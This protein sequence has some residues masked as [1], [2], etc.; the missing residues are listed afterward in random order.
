LDRDQILQNL[1]NRKLDDTT[2]TRVQESYPLS[3]R[4]PTC[5]GT[6]KYMLNGE[7]HACDCQLQLLLQ[8]HYFASNIGREYHDICA[9]SHF[10]GPDRDLVI[11]VIREYLD[12]YED[13][14]HYGIGLTFSGPLG[15]GKTFA[16]TSVLKDLIQRGH[17]VYFINFN[18]MIEVWG[19]SWHDDKAKKML[20]DKLKRVDVLGIDEV[21]TDKRNLTGFLA[22]GFDAVI[23]H[24]TSNL[25]PTLITTNMSKNQERAEFSK[26]Y[27]LLS[28]R[29]V[30]VDFTGHDRRQGEIRQTV[31]GLRNAGERRPIC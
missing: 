22:S 23:R 19:S 2:F 26:V 27:S 31:F 8:K 11:P 18:E 17:T 14:F 4:C 10:E 25:L 9:F 30:R 5:D 28:A 16:M 12:K 13:N 7:E 21:T 29:N 6:K 24:R 1:V 3:S 20:Q 15:T